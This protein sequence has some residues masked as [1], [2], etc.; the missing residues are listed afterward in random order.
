LRTPHCAA[1]LRIQRAAGA[2]GNARSS[3]A[4]AAAP[5]TV[6]VPAV[7]VPVVAAAGVRAEPAHADAQALQRAEHGA[8]D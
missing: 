7:A 1:A 3:A 5:A 2:F 8:A 6:A 4:R